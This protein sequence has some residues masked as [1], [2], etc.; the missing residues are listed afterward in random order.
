L[1]QVNIALLAFLAVLLVALSVI[2]GIGLHRLATV[3]IG[4]PEA[5][6]RAFCMDEVQANYADAY[7]WLAPGATVYTQSEFLAASMTRDLHVGGVGS[8]TIAGRDIWGTIVGFHA[9]ALSVAVNS[10]GATTISLDQF[11]RKGGHPVW[12]ISEVNSGFDLLAVST[13]PEE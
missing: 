2:V 1:R 9:I 10:G 3:P 5:T 12:L 11:S 7:T 6:V 13:P 8:C 4:G